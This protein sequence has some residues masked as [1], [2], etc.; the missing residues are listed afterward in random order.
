MKLFGKDLDHNVVVVAEIGVNHEGDPEVAARLIDLAAES[1]V[2]AVKLQTY[3]PE[4]YAS[5]SDPERLKRVSRFSLDQVVFRRLVTHADRRGIP[6][7]STALTEDVVPLLAELCPAIKIASGD[8]TFEPVVRA[9][10][11]TKKPVIISTGNGTVEEIDCAIA[12]CRD[13]IGDARLQDRLVLMHC[14]SAYPTPIEQANVLSVPYLKQRYG[15]TTGYSNHVIEPEAVLAAVAL[16]AQVIE[17]HVTD[18]KVGREFRDHAMSFEPAEVCALVQSIHRVR[19][20]LGS[21]GKIIQEC[22]RPLR[23]VIRKGLVAARKLTAGT[24]LMKEHVMYAR[25]ATKIS[26]GE[27]PDILGK[28]L[29]R[30]LGRGELISRQDLR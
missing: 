27:L 3:T 2:D 10:T 19:A 16:G 28:T 1:G 14:V 30:D 22:E 13:E 20:S 26:A 5:A 11:A 18:R 4:R 8:L 23:E 7:F 24:V 25:P 12:W 9:A 21:V 29:M 15:L 17:V 6:L